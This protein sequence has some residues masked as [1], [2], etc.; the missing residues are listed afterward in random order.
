MLRK[1]D[2]FIDGKWIAPA[3]PKELEVIN[4]ADEQPFAVISL[5]SAADVD[6][7][8]AAARRAFDGWSR[9]S[10]EERL[11]ALERLLAAYQRRMDDMA[12]AISDEMG[13]PIKLAIESQAA[14]GAG[15][16]KSFI[17]T[18]R[19][20][21]FEHALDER[22]P[23][24]RIVH[25]PIGVCGLITP[26]N[27]PMNQ[28]TLKVVPAIAAGCTVVLKPSE[29]AP[30]SSIVFAEMMEEAGFPAGVFNMVNGDGPTVGEALSR[31]PGIDMMSF[32]GSTRAGIAV[33]KAAADTIKRVALELGGKSPNIVFADSDLPDAIARGLA[34]CFENTGQ[35]CNAP[36]RMLVER[37]VYDRAVSLAA[38]YA[39]TV[40]VGNPAE[41]GDHIGPLVS[42]VQFNKV[43]GLIEAG[44]NDWGGVSPITPDFVN[45][46]APWPHV[47]DLAR[48]TREAGKELVQ[49]LAIYPQWARDP[50]RWLHPA[51]IAPV[52]R[53]IDGEGYARE[54]NWFPGAEAHAADVA[55]LLQAPGKPRSHIETIMERLRAGVPPDEDMVVGLLRAR[56]ADAALVCRAA[57]EL[58][59]RTNGD[60]VTYV[61][62]RNI[63]YTNVCQYRCKF[64]AFSKGKLAEH[65]RGKPYD[66]SIDEI[67]RRTVEAWQRGAT[68][69][70]MQGGIH[71][72]Y[73]GDTYLDICSAVKAAVPEMHIHAFS[74]LEV[75]QGART[76]GLPL[77]DYLARLQ[78][79]G[80]ATL[81]GTAAEILDDEVRA[82]ICP[83]KVT[84][85][86]WL[87]VME[88]AH[89]LG[90]RSTATIMF[91]H[92]DR[93][94]HWARHL[95][96][97]RDLQARSGGFTEFVPLPF[98]HMEAPVYRRGGARRGPTF[99]EAVL[100][101]AVARLVLHPLIPNIQTSWVKMGIEGASACL[102]A[103]A[104]DLGGTLMNESISR[105]A[106]AQHGQE[107]TA[108]DMERLIRGLGRV[109]RQRTT[110]YAEVQPSAVPGRLAGGADR[111]GAAP[112]AT[113]TI[114]PRTP[115]D[116]GAT[117]PKV[118]PR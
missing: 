47:D 13:A 80:L 117:C 37:P 55:A 50:E 49:R 35:S 21:T 20:F 15:H 12:R 7:A 69:V 68:E 28:V 102:G 101:H 10:R 79:A 14:C 98:V 34:H 42:E 29:V 100:M 85:T 111:Y 38:D 22:N 78:E 70:C 72:D 2:F 106:G 116:D 31:H 57:D 66:L 110:L 8:V 63:N 93:P 27:W 45:P 83:D 58:R 76:L 103:G 73:T 84:T 24:E 36:T 56:G 105:A 75:T 5:G 104:N 107:M 99:R 19:S 44:I 91:G 16:I 11:A 53:E 25:E 33:S 30:V 41:D 61:V 89:G 108:A 88:T 65:L 4:P 48:H 96:H 109:P 86:E 1:T 67:Q 87:E 113:I 43:Q 112:P 40:K 94:E 92:T 74:P 39:A 52:L 82:L 95:L 32:T 6:K 26:W 59:R 81:P 114:Q 9:T 54:N 23:Q 60:V 51:T 118:S 90:L 115:G 97:I 71:P 46:E 3:V 17:R 62:N 77:R 64:C 18:L